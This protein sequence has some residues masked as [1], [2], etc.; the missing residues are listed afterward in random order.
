LHQQLEVCHSRSPARVASVV[1]LVRSSF[2]S[3]DRNALQVLSSP[4]MRAPP[5]PGAEPEVRFLKF[6]E[7]SEHC[8]LVQKFKPQ[9]LLRSV[10][11][12]RNRFAMS[13]AG[14]RSLQSAEPRALP[15]AGGRDAAA[16]AEQRRRPLGAGQH[17]QA[18]INRSSRT[19]IFADRQ[20]SWTTMLAP[21]QSPNA[22]VSLNLNV[23]SVLAPVL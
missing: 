4:Y 3:V 2:Y 18:Q 11:A 20:R 8:I 10:N 6:T 17:H 15:G 16:D 22:I 9:V 19:S 12:S 13:D 23:R 14:P 21:I 5:A 1:I 7:S